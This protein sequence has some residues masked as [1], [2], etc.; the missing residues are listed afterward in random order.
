LGI[1]AA[2]DHTPLRGGGGASP[3]PATGERRPDWA[4]ITRL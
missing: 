1:V 3:S 4:A 2:F